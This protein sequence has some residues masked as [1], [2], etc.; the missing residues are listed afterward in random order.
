VQLTEPVIA[1]CAW[2]CDDPS[3]L[4]RPAHVQALDGEGTAEQGPV[5]FD[6]AE[7]PVYR[8]VLADA[9]AG[10]QLTECP[11]GGSAGERSKQRPNLLWPE[12]I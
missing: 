4:L 12:A 7:H 8:D 9:V 10:E 2:R 6:E 3:R 11:D 1:Q 5:A